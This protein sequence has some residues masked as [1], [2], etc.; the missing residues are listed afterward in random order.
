MLEMKPKHVGGGKFAAL[1]A[2][3]SFVSA[4]SSVSICDPIFC[5]VPHT[6][7]APVEPL[8]TAFQ[9]IQRIEFVEEYVGEREHS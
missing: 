9:L 2:G 7:L 6:P 1:K 4:R 8:A 3:F 5:G